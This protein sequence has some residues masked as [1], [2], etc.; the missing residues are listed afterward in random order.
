MPARTSRPW[1]ILV[2]PVPL[3]VPLSVS[4]VPLFT[5]M[6]VKLLF[7]TIDVVP[8]PQLLVPAMFRRPPLGE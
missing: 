6:P 4:V 5:S 8:V 3:T 2:S 1:L 7:R